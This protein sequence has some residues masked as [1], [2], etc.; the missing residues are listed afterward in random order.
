[1]HAEAHGDR[2]AAL[3]Q[4]LADLGEAEQPLAQT[5]QTARHHQAAEAC[6]QEFAQLR[7]R[8]APQSVDLGRLRRQYSLGYCPGRLQ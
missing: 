2:G 7:L 1:M 4:H 6:L 5:A 8:P 3:G